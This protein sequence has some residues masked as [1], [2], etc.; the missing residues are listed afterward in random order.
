V[1]AQKKRGGRNGIF[2]D[3]LF[4]SLF[5]NQPERIRMQTNS[6][7]VNVKPIPTKEPVDGVGLFNAY[8]ASIS[9]TQAQTHEP[10]TLSLDLEGNGNFEQITIPKL[11]L[12]EGIKYYESKNE[13]ID[14]SADG[15]APGKKHFEFVLQATKAGNLSIPEQKFSFFDT[16]HRRVTT[17]STDPISLTISKASGSNENSSISSTTTQPTEQ[18]KSE[19][20]QNQP[21]TPNTK[22]HP[23]ALPWWIFVLLLITPMLFYAK[24]IWQACMRCFD[25]I[26][27]K[28]QAS[29]AHQKKQFAALIKK[30]DLDGIYTFF[31]TYIALQK[32]I[33]TAS[34]STDDLE[35]YLAQRGFD[36]EKIDDFITF[37]GNC[38][39]AKYG[40]KALH[41]NE[42][43]ALLNK[44]Q[45]WFLMLV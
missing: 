8:R 32:N 45:Y 38:S 27:R 24:T 11:N 15:A 13:T 34:V 22:H 40:Q 10:L 41:S 6:L 39:R 28:N 42:Q 17:L 18:P 14:Q 19:Q 5:G 37:L 26:T 33:A 2:D 7:Q 44:A 31:I 30:Q 43:E 1:P 16:A 20:P 12:P 36:F 35:Q 3:D 9:A 25:F 29:K 4:S 23:E 21:S